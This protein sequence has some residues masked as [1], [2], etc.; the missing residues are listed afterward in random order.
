M[1]QGQWFAVATK[2][3]QEKV[4]EVNLSRQGYRAVLPL[5]EVR[6]RRQNKWTNV[7]EPLFSGYLFVLLELGKDNLVPIRSTLGCRDLVRIGPGLVPVPEAVMTPLLSW[8]LSPKTV[9]V[10]FSEGDEVAIAAGS[11]AGLQGVF[12]LAKGNDRA[13]VFIAMLGK[14]R[15][16]TVA[17]GDLAVP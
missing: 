7:I 1:S 5:M 6:K 14:E 9:E 12:R 15:P 13:E 10:L 2:P 17:L 11:F 4:A 16:M 3:R 8:S